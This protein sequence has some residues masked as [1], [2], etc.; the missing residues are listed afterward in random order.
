VPEYEYG[1][2]PLAPDTF[3]FL[4]RPGWGWS[5][6]GLIADGEDAVLVDTAYTPALAAAMLAEMAAARPGANIS[7][8]VL[9][10]GNG[11]HSFGAVAL[12]ASV[13]LVTSR[14][15]ADSL[16]TEVSPAAM[17]S[18]MS[19]GPE[20]LRSYMAE[21]FGCFDYSEAALP[22]ADT[23]F[24]GRTELT[25]GSRRIELIEVGP[26]HTEGDV[27]VYVPDAGVLYTGDIV[28]VGDAP[29]A[30][31]SARGV[32]EACHTLA[33]TG[34]RVLVPGHGPVVEVSYLD[35]LS[36]YFET[37]LEHAERLGAAG[38]PYHEAAARIP[39]GAHP[40]QGLA[41]RVVISTA[42]AYRDLGFPVEDDVVGVLSHMAALAAARSANTNQ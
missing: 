4:R 23:T 21:H 2:T 26:A 36:R 15:C 24:E 12:P 8:C 41:E 18:I 35:Q 3:A 13:E 39:L 34:A 25:V 38:V 32:L 37:L 19:A 17:T 9:T 11:D 30:W 14:A 40:D 33:Q 1:L 6:S 31:A 29:I 20:P 5:N 28:F 16:E 7:R 22:K 27:A 10:H 42:A